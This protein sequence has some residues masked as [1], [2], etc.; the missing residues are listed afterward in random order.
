MILG[1]RTSMMNL[2]KSLN[3]ILYDHYIKSLHFSMGVTK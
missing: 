1:L 2:K 3:E